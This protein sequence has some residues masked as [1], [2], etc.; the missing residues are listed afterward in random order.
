MKKFKG[1]INVLY[2][3]TKHVSL[4]ILCFGV[5]SFSRS[6]LFQGCFVCRYNAIKFEI[7]IQY[8]RFNSHWKAK[9]KGNAVLLCNDNFISTIDILSNSVSMPQQKYYQQAEDYDIEALRVE[10]R[11]TIWIKKLENN[12]TSLLSSFQLCTI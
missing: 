3:L 11:V 4:V 6:I 9:R 8:Y 10:W 5:T 12:G 2:P 7:S 1:S